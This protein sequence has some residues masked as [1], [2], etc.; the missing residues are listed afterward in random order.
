MREALRDAALG[1]DEVHL[2]VAVVLAGEGDGLP[3][4][5]EPGNISNPTSLVR[6]LAMPPEAGTV[7]RSPA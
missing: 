7:Y 4:R 6:R 2:G 5:R 1:G 3:V